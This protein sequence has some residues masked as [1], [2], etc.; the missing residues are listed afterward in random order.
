[1]DSNLAEAVQLQLW[2]DEDIAK[3]QV[4]PAMEIQEEDQSTT[5]TSF[6]TQLYL[7]GFYP[8]GDK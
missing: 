4:V 3:I 7:P 2:L 1:M 8:E 6:A 5:Q